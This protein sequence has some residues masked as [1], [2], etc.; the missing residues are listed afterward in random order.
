MASDLARSRAASAAYRALFWSVVVVTDPRSRV[1][2]TRNVIAMKVMTE[3]RMR[4]ITNAIP[5]WLNAECGVRN[6]EWCGTKELN[7]LNELNGGAERWS[8]G[9]LER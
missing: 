7:R 9:A 3:S 1:A 4:V 2:R 6:A 5:R 8:V